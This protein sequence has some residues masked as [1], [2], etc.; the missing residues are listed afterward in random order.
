MT[1]EPTQ[2]ADTRSPRTTL[3]MSPPIRSYL[4]W[5]SSS[6]DVSDR[7]TSSASSSGCF[8]GEGEVGDIGDGDGDA[9][10]Q[11]I[12]ELSLDPWKKSNPH[13]SKE[14]RVDNFGWDPWD[15]P[16]LKALCFH[17]L[18]RNGQGRD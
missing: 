1:F 2:N 11:E 6:S 14:K 15:S 8:E 4:S 13:V 10:V 3:A 12:V 5:G 7:S 9:I 18:H 16:H 17:S